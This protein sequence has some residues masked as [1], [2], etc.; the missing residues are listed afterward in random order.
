MSPTPIVVNQT[1]A[2]KIRRKKF[3]RSPQPSKPIPSENS[4]NSKQFE[5]PKFAETKIT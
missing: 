2:P 4:F 3:E 5:V 1:S